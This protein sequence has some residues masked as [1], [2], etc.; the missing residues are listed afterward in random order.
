LETTIKKLVMMH[1][2]EK[3]FEV[4]W[5]K[6]LCITIKKYWKN[7]ASWLLALSCKQS[8]D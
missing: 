5:F 7:F 3:V 1:F 2:K 4:K 6:L 8:V